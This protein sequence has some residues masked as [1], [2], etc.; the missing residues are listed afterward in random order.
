VFEWL[1]S[2]VS[3]DTVVFDGCYSSITVVLLYFDSG[4]T[5]AVPQYTSMINVV[6]VF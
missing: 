5:V 4:C 6:Y 1:Y 2:G 3:G